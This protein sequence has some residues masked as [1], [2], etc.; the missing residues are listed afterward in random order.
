MEPLRSEYEVP[1]LSPIAMKFARRLAVWGA[2]CLLV[3]ASGGSVFAAQC[4]GFP[5]GWHTSSGPANTVD[6]SVSGSKLPNAPAHPL[7]AP[8]QCRG[9]SCSPAAP[10]QA[11]DQRVVTG[12]MNDGILVRTIGFQRSPSDVEFPDAV[13]ALLRYEVVLGV[14]RPP[15]G[16]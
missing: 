11:P 16:V 4:G 8:C 14:L 7:P 15:C 5:K 1:S 2:V 6:F 13:T 12:Q 9:L 3:L 10:V